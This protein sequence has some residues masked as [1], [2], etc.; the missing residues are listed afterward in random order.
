MIFCFLLKPFFAEPF[1]SANERTR[2]APPL[3]FD[4]GSFLFP[5]KGSFLSGGGRNDGFQ[6]VRRA[7]GPAYAS[8]Q[9]YYPPMGQGTV[10]VSRSNVVKKTTSQNLWP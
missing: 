6:G 8:S 3:P 10:L 1:G 7:P 9:P 5:G 2:R 4:S